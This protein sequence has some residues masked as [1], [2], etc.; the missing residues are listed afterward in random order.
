M[1]PINPKNIDVTDNI[2]AFKLFYLNIFNI[3]VVFVEVI[4]NLE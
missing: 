3:M 2:E 4:V 1:V